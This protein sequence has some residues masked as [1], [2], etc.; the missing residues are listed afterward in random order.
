MAA[1]LDEFLQ[2]GLGILAE[3]AQVDVRQDRAIQVFDDAADFRIAAIQVDGAEDGLQRV[4]Q[5]RGPA[6]APAFQLALAQAQVGRQRQALGD[7]GQGGLLD[8]VR[9]HPRQVA[10][11]HFG[12]LGEQQR[13]NDEIQ[14]GIPQ[15][16]QALVV[17]HAM[18][19]VGQGPLQQGRIP[20]AVVQGGLQGFQGGHHSNPPIRLGEP[21]FIQMKKARPTMLRSGTKPQ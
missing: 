7:V 9:A 14:H 6:K 10:F 8:Q 15:E 16:F 2:Q 1:P 13:G 5:D 17:R 20:K 11:V 21:K 19:A 18:A 4:G 3:G 12:V